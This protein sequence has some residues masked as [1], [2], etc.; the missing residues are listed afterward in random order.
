MVTQNAAF[1]VGATERARRAQARLRRRHRDLQHLRP[2]RTTA[3][4]STPASRTSSSS[5]AAAR[6]LYGDD[7]LLVAEGPGRRHCEDLDVCGIKKK[8]CVKQD[9]GTIDLKTLLA[10]TVKNP[11]NNNVAEP[12]YPLFFCRDKTPEER[13]ELRA[14]AWPDG[15]GRDRL[16][17]RGRRDGRRQGRRR[18]RGRRTTTARPSSTR[19][20]RW[21][22]TSRAT[23]TATAS[24]TR[25]TSA[26]SSTGETCTLPSGDD[27]DDDGV[28]ERRRQLPRARERRSGRRRQGRQGQ[29]V[30]RVPEH[31]EPRLR[32]SARPST[33]CSSSAIRRPRGTPWP[34]RPARA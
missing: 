19:S 25:A 10:Q 24:A 13:A 30:R 22:A 33:P 23:A 18:R 28:S 4:S 32:S 11:T 2:A 8:A 34:A 29:R 1:A 20:A 16:D 5:S 12:L 7:A 27:L 17:L 21:T 14:L 15:V 31:A 6:S 9:L 3:P 26:R